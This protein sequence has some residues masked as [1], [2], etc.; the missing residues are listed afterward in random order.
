M[1][2]ENKVFLGAL[3]IAV[4][5]IAGLVFQSFGKKPVA[6]GGSG[7]SIPTFAVIGS[8]SSYYSFST[9]AT[10]TANVFLGG[11][12]D[13][14]D[15][16][17]DYNA[18]PTALILWHQYYSF[19]SAC[20]GST[21]PG[22]ASVRWYGEDSDTVSSAVDTHSASTTVHTWTPTDV[23]INRKNTKILTPNAQC[24]LLEF[25][26]ASTTDSSELRVDV[27]SKINSN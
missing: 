25:F 11:D 10:T 8:A 19:D 21:D 20:T 13:Q 27:N 15:L 2:K 26:T 18:S 16:G 7:S 17:L 24:M 6:L 1:N 14:V 12:I 22:S 23:G 5:A 4:L 3:A 9:N